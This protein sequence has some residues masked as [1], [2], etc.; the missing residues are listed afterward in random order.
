MRQ[1]LNNGTISRIRRP[2]R[3]IHPCTCAHIQPAADLLARHAYCRVS[4]AGDR[5]SISPDESD[6]RIERALAARARLDL[7]ADDRLDLDD[8]RA[9]S[10]GFERGIPPRLRQRNMDADSSARRD[11]HNDNR[12][13]AHRP[14]CAPIAAAGLRGHGRGARSR[15]RTEHN[16]PTDAGRRQGHDRH[17]RERRSVH[18]HESRRPCHHRGRHEP[19]GTPSPPSAQHRA[20]RSH[21]D[22]ITKGLEHLGSD[23]GD[24]QQIIDAREPPVRLPPLDDPSGNGWPHARE[25]VERSF[26]RAVQVHPAV[27]RDTGRSSCR[28]LPHARHDHLL[29]IRYGAR[30][31]DPGSLGILGESS[32]RSHRIDDPRI[33]VQNVQPWSVHSSRDVDIERGGRRGH[34]HRRWG[35]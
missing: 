7:A 14:R 30:K 15:D 24:R 11:S 21:R 28:C 2:A 23:P 3:S 25:R 27:G 9:A 18:Q 4:P 34:R 26:I 13:N 29:P 5:T 19:R 22:E 12:Q 6:R 8:T 17:R 35:Q 1:D 33:G 10:E 16:S 32:C 20:A 31:I